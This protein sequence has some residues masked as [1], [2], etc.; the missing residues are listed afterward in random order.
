MW[1]VFYSISNS[2]NSQAPMCENKR[3]PQSEFLPAGPGSKLQHLSS[4]H[5]AC[6]LQT[7]Q[8]FFVQIYVSSE[9]ITFEYTVHLL[10]PY[11]MYII[12]NI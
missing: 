12:Y 7:F 1:Y 6:V 3:P 5:V 9:L 10:A 11:M 2:I 4:Q 8:C